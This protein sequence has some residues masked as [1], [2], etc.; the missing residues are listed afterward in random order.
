MST[1]Y[2]SKLRQ[3]PICRAKYTM[4]FNERIS[5]Y[6]ECNCFVVYLFRKDLKESQPLTHRLCMQGL[7]CY[8]FVIRR[9]EKIRTHFRFGKLGS[10]YTGLVR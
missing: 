6:E 10:D 5:L 2:M 4:F 1:V 3:I 9:K 7:V 8:T